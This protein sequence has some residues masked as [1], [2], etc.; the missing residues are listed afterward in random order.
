MKNTKIRSKNTS[1]ILF[2]ICFVSLLC[3][4]LSL[5][6]WDLELRVMHYDEA[7]HLYYAW[8]LFSEGVYIHSP[9]MHGPFQ[10]EISALIFKLLG[11]SDFT[12]RL[13]YVFFGTALVALPY[14]LRSYWGSLPSFMVSIFLTISPSLWYFS[15]F[16]RNDI[17]V[18][19]WATSL[20]IIFWNYSNANRAKY[21]YLASAIMALLFST[22]ETSFFITLIFL[23]FG[24]VL[25]INQLA[26][27]IFRRFR[28]RDITG[29]AGFFIL[30]L[31]LTLPQWAPLSGLFQSILGVYVVNPDGVVSGLVGAPLWAPPLVDFPLYGSSIWV[32]GALILCMIS[33]LSLSCA[34]RPIKLGHILNTILVCGASTSCGYVLAQAISKFIHSDSSLITSI[35]FI[36]FSCLAVGYCRFS[37]GLSRKHVLLLILIPIA[38]MLLIS[39]L[40]THWLNPELLAVHLLPSEVQTGDV[41]LGVP[42]NFL[43]ASSLILSL[44]LASIVIGIIW[45]GVEWIYCALIFYSIWILTHTTLLTNPTGIFTGGWQ[46]LGYWIAQQEVARGNQPWYYYILGLSVYEFMLLILGI[47]GCSYFLKRGHI[48][49]ITLST[50]AVLSVVAYTIAS[51]KMP[52]L[53]VNLALPLAFVSGYYISLVITDIQWKKIHFESLICLC[54]TP[55]IILLLGF[56]IF[57]SQSILSVIIAISLTAIMLLMF[58]F[59]AR[60]SRELRIRSLIS[61]GLFVTLFI[62]TVF[63]SIRTVYYVDDNY[64]ELLVYAQGS[65]DLKHSLIEISH[66]VDKNFVDDNSMSV[67][68][69]MWFP[70]QWYLRHITDTNALNFECF[71]TED[72]KGWNDSCID[73]NANEINSLT[74]I[75]DP[76]RIANVD[77]LDGLH[78]SELFRNLL[79]FPEIY[80]RPGENRQS[81]PIINEMTRDFSFFI[82]SAKDISK[83]RSAGDYFLYRKLGSDWYYSGYYEYSPK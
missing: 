67:D 57:V 47:I 62:A 6:L 44:L 43:V 20:F 61:I 10:I 25:G 38:F 42:I 8:K 15:R 69:D 37:I 56:I 13:A 68:Y 65:Q 70:I 16:G 7:I 45:K 46:G 73:P 79:W 27:L 14:F 78:E 29:S 54:L 3:L 74:L 82:D 77:N 64:P 71:K 21:L 55:L 9:W 12:G 40:F 58:A 32:Y 49:G 11:D 75:T 26:P 60:Y 39:S 22:K 76:N 28:L 66:L 19:F 80:R 23:A 18:A 31:T 4:A 33:A 17:I 52:W 50:W 36:F 53:L 81:T 30:L 35:M 41:S 83:W 1:N 34:K 59:C 72:S 48:L 63:T 2:H 24:F 5:R 51:E